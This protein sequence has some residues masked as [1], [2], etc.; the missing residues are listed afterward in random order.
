MAGV[1]ARAQKTWGNL[2]KERDISF[3]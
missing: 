1:V 3:D 2:A